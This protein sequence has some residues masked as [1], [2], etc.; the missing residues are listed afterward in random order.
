MS[1]LKLPSR[2]DKNIKNSRD[3]LNQERLTIV[4]HTSA[5]AEIGPKD[6]PG[7][8]TRFLD[9][10]LV[11]FRDRCSVRC[12][13]SKFLSLKRHQLLRPDVNFSQILASQSL[14]ISTELTW[15]IKMPNGLMLNAAVAVLLNKI[16][17]L[18][19]LKRKSETF[20]PISISRSK[21]YLVKFREQWPIQQCKQ[22]FAMPKIAIITW[23]SGPLP[24]QLK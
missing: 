17:K 11:D 22:H 14:R 23:L 6:M 5:M 15:T 7:H 16:L 24:M 1:F 13:K 3:K 10:F 8:F 9:R 4:D 19:S 12:P 21:L 20:G 18:F 2:K